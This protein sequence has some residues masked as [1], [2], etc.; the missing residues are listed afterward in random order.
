MWGPVASFPEPHRLWI[1]STVVVVYNPE[2]VDSEHPDR[3]VWPGTRWEWA[4]LRPENGT[5]DA[6]TYHDGYARQKWFYQAQIESPA[7]I[8]TSQPVDLHFGPTAP[9]G[10]RQPLDPNHPRSGLV[11]LL[12]HLRTHPTSL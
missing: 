12:P 2:L 11:R 3:V 10:M 7:G 9:R 6:P 4:V 8:D 1:P 5:F